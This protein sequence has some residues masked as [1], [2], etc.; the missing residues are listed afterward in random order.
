MVRGRT[1]GLEQTGRRPS[2]ATVRQRQSAK[3]MEILNVMWDPLGIGLLALRF[4][5]DTQ[6]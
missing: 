5:I 1:G 6:M 4:A 3:M 2:G